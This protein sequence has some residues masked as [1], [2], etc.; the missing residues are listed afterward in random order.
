M[1]SSRKLNIFNHTNPM[2]FFQILWILWM[3]ASSCLRL[4]RP[5]IVL[6]WPKVWLEIGIIATI[7]TIFND[8]KFTQIVGK[9]LL[10]SK[11]FRGI[12]ATSAHARIIVISFVA[13]IK[14]S[15]ENFYHL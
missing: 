14:I 5:T 10:N 3:G 13:I 2:R 8:V 9:K 12:I 7:A 4:Y 11:T 6:L 1:F 15:L